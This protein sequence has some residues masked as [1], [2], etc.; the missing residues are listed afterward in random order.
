VRIP[1]SPKKPVAPGG[2]GPAHFP[3][4]RKGDI[5]MTVTF[6]GGGF[7]NVRWIRV[8]VK[9]LYREGPHLIGIISEAQ[10]KKIKR[11]Y[12]P[13]KDCLCRSYP[14]IEPHEKGECTIV[15]DPRA[16]FQSSE[17]KPKGF[18]EMIDGE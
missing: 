9:D 5:V 17:P 8:R 14:W 2:T 3:T 10:A 6:P 15:V 16:T 7:H 11:H 18:W 12:C 13:Y 1:D 4:K